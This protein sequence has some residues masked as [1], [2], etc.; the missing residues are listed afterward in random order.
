M[1]GTAGV[2]QDAAVSKMCAGAQTWVQTC[3]CGWERRLVLVTDTVRR[4]PGGVRTCRR[5]QRCGAEVAYV[6]EGCSQ[7]MNDVGIMSPNRI[8]PFIWVSAAPPALRH[9]RAAPRGSSRRESLGTSLL[10]APTGH[11][12]ECGAAGADAYRQ[13]SRPMFSSG[14]KGVEGQ[15]HPAWVQL[16]GPQLHMR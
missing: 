7:Q 2:R 13:L 5:P 16:G 10:R 6:A 12:G 11:A 4:P 15:R 1:P 8:A 14:P 9:R 3:A